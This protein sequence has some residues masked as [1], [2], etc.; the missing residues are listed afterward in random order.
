MARTSQRDAV[1]EAASAL[2]QQ[3][4][5]TADTAFLDSCVLHH[6]ELRASTSSSSG[7]AATTEIV[8]RVSHKLLE[9]GVQQHNIRGDEWWPTYRLWRFVDDDDD[10]D[11]QRDDSGV[12]AES[13]RRGGI[14]SRQ[15]IRRAFEAESAD[16]G[17]GPV[18]SRPPRARESRQ[19]RQRRVPDLTTERN[20]AL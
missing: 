19:R 5:P 6:L 18:R 1:R 12:D 11:E 7:S 16:R 14:A 20:L 17:S 10:D 4:F 2:L 9:E 8:E 13:P 3:L 15:E